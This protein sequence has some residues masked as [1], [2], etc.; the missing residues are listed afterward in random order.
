VAR[1]ASAALR[2][3]AEVESAL[4]A[5][6]FLAERERHLAEAAKQSTA[7]RQL[8]EERY[9]AG[10]EAYVTVLESQR[11]AAVAESEWITARRLR[12]DNR[13]DLHLALGGGFRAPNE[14]AS[15]SDSGERAAQA[16]AGNE[17]DAS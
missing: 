12:L 10:L 8:A 16:T 1:F 7:A 6:A 14:E 11:R 15:D 2:A 3:Y 13:V 9:R 5:D 4:A 17:E